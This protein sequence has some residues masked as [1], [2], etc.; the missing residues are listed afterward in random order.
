MKPRDPRQQT[1]RPHKSRHQPHRLRQSLARL[2]M[3]AL[4]RTRRSY[5]IMRLRLLVRQ[6]HHP[7]RRRLRLRP[8]PQP[9]L[10]PRQPMPRRARL[11]IVLQNRPEQTNRFLRRPTPQR[12]RRTPLHH[13]VLPPI[14]FRQFPHQRH[15]RRSV[16]PQHRPA[17]PQH[18]HRTHRKPR[19]R[20][21][22]PHFLPTLL[23]PPLKPLMP[24][25]P[26][27]T[28]LQHRLQPR[29]PPLQPAKLH[30]VQLS[31]AHAQRQHFINHPGRL[32]RPLQPH[33]TLHLQ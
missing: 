28:N 8:L 24:L 7:P 11:R 5:Q 30:P 26:P 10:R 19:L 3:L 31:K 17:H 12:Q 15:H 18:L 9:R 27:L 14:R 1:E 4:K 25:R 23:H 13:I 6:R 33:Q 16:P 20:L 2:I 32:H 22:R 21:S 29:L